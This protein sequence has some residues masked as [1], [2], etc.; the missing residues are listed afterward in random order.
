MLRDE[1]VF[2]D[3]HLPDPIVGRNRHMNEV[4][5][6]LARIARLSEGYARRAITALRVAVRM[7]SQEGLATILGRLVEDTDGLP[8]AEEWLTTEI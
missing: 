4:T 6:A 7:A 1:E 8:N 3:D 2:E 5:D